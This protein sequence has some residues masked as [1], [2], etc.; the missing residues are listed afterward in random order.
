MKWTVPPA[1]PGKPPMTLPAP[2][3]CG[4]YFDVGFVPPLAAMQLA[5]PDSASRTWTLPNGE[6]IQ[7]PPPVRFGLRIRRQAEDAY[8]VTLLWDT[9]YR[10]WFSLRRRELLN[11][12]LG[13]ILAAL[14]TPLEGVLDQPASAA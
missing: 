14:G 9:T 10:Q 4:S 1:L 7:G 8:A 6:S 11:S 3:V 5:W 13:T 2:Q 12:S